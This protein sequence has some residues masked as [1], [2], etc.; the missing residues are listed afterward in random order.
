M[1]KTKDDFEEK[2]DVNKEKYDSRPSKKELEETVNNLEENGF[3][4]KVV[5]T[6]EKALEEIKGLVEDD[7]S[8]MI[9]HSTTLEQIEFVDY[10]NEGEHDWHN[11]YGEVFSIDDD[12]KRAKKRREAQA[13]DYFLGSVNAISKTGELVAADLSGSRVGAYP[14]AAGNVVIVSGTNKIM[15]DLDSAR[16]RLWE[17]AYRFENERAQEAYG[18]ESAVAKELTYRQETEGRTTIVLIKEELGY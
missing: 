1:P 3:N 14:F 12:E 15:G 7:S 17:Y 10:L 5:E 4:V 6:G 11:V 18:V 13:S 16:D 2:V 8:V 9:G